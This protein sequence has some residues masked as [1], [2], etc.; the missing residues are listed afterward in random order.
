MKKVL[1]IIFQG[2]IIILASGNTDADN[3]PNE[4]L[5]RNWHTRMIQVHVHVGGCGFKSRQLHTMKTEIR[6][7]LRFL[8]YALPA[9]RISVK[10]LSRKAKA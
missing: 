5:W 4:Q 10:T 7:D 3:T 1:T 2:V 6:K 9:L 8:R